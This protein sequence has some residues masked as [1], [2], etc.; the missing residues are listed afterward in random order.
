MDDMEYL[1]RQSVALRSASPSFRMTS[2]ARSVSSET[3]GI[4]AWTHH[5]LCDLRRAA[6]KNGG[7]VIPILL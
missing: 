2:R 7:R 6:E 1:R 5:L 4:E 3:T